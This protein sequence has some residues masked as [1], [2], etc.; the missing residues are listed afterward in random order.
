MNPRRNKLSVRGVVVFLVIVLFLFGP[1]RGIVKKTVAYVARF[2]YPEYSVGILDTRIA[3]MN[4]ALKDINEE[5]MR[6]RSIVDDGGG[7][8]QSRVS[9]GKSFLFGDSL[10]L[11]SGSRE[12]VDVGFPV[13]VDGHLVLGTISEVGVTWSKVDL[14]SQIG[15]KQILRM[16]KQNEIV[17]EASGIGGGR[18]SATIPKAVDVVVGDIIRWGLDTR[19]IVGIIDSIKRF[20]GRQLQELAIRRSVPLSSIT[21]VDVVLVDTIKNNE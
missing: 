14:F 8:I 7:I 9:F 21:Y 5:N 2:F 20:E 17:F 12:G 1:V 19:Y 11:S 18:L 16:G 13:V 15:T 3:V 6:L 10:L 4:D